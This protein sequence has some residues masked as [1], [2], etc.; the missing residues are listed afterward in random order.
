MDGQTLNS[1][2][3]ENVL[4]DFRQKTVPEISIYLLISVSEEVQICKGSNI[5]KLTGSVTY[6]PP[7][8][9]RAPFCSCD[10]HLLAVLMRKPCAFFGHQP[11]LQCIKNGCRSSSLQP[12]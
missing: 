1:V 10:R 9:A 2:N 4:W 8:S 6:G 5:Y 11:T 12:I 3:G 7:V